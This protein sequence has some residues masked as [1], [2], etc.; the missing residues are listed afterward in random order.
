[1]KRAFL[2]PGQG[3]QFVGMGKD[4]YE[5]YEEVRNIYD[6]ATK[7]SNIDVAKICFEGP[8]E[9][10]NRTEYTQIAIFTTSLAFLKIL[11]QK[12][13]TADIAVGLSLGEYAALVY[14]GILNIED[15]LK[16][17]TKRGYYMENLCEQNKEYAMA[18]IMGL[19]VEIIEQICKEFYYKGKFVVPANYNYSGQT[20][21]A[22]EKEIMDEVIQ[23]LK[24]HNAKK[25]VI[26]K[27]TRPFH[28]EKLIKAKQAYSKELENINFNLENTKVKVIK[29]IDGTIYK[30]TDNLKEILANHIISPVRFDKAI[31]QMQ[32]ENI[33]EFIEIGPRKDINRFYKKRG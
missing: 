31:K 4:L 2:F 15:G 8:E 17:I 3:S 28:T 18:A 25:V 26:L 27:T 14:G 21:I 30:K 23:K 33:E 20:V 6:L 7:I 19:N 12:N 24:E 16:L 22:T 13:I 11:T 5:K 1:M 10:L 32:D 9:L 29:N